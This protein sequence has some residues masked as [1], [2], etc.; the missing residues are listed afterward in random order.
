MTGL[1]SVVGRAVGEAPEVGPLAHDADR[2]VLLSRRAHTLAPRAGWLLRREELGVLT[3]PSGQVMACDPTYESFEVEPFTRLVRPGRYP[4]VV[5]HAVQDGHEHGWIAAAAIVLR[6]EAPA[7]WELA[8]CAGQRLA[9]LRPGEFYGYGVDGGTGCFVDAETAAEF[10]SRRHF[11]RM[12]KAFERGDHRPMV[13]VHRDEPAVAVFMSGL[14][15][16]CYASYWGL[17]AR[18]EPVCLVTDFGV[19]TDVQTARL[20]FGEEAPLTA[21]RL[22]HPALARAGAEVTLRSAA[23]D[24][25]KIEVRGA[26]HAVQEVRLLAR[27]AEGWAPRGCDSELTDGPEGMTRRLTPRPAPE[28]WGLELEVMVGAALVRAEEE[29]VARAPV[30]RRRRA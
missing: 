9:D 10:A 6:D 26:A 17:D 5:T 30:L 2:R 21:C 4:V 15:D 18:G 29:P 7:R 22:E 25:L 12:L 13:H 20:R 16:G 1:S 27:E 8:L 28:R 19:L 11:S 3:L 24:D 14:G 23:P